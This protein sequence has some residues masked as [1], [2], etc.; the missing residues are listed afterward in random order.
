M[1]TNLWNQDYYKLTKKVMA[2]T[3]QYSIEDGKGNM[4]G[5]TKQ[6]MFKLK[7]DIR[8]Y[9]DDKMVTEL[10]RI[11]QDQ[12][13]DM[14]GT[15][16]VIDSSSNTCVGKIKRSP[17]SDI[18]ADSYDIMEPNGLIMGRILES[19]GRGL[20]RKYLPGGN[21]IP[22]QVC[23]E[24]NGKKVADVKQNFKMIGDS[25]EVRCNEIPAQLNRRTLVAAMLMMSMIERQKK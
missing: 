20:M 16:S 9:T 6:K 2:L 7:E 18:G 23:V 21:L 15:F 8:V 13:M 24:C 25:W 10:F 3:N 12:V 22:E 4:L 14:W 1:E 17:L 11:Q 5:Y 19:S